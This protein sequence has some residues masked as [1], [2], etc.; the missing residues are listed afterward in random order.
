MGLPLDFLEEKKF[1]K[2]F[3]LILQAE[4][5]SKVCLKAACGGLM[6]VT[7]SWWSSLYVSLHTNVLGLFYKVYCCFLH[8]S[9]IEF[10]C[11]EGKCMQCICVVT[12][13][14]RLARDLVVIKS[15][16]K[17]ISDLHACASRCKHVTC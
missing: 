17:S 16:I 9:C 5:L 2:V 14:D 12:A 15:T 3:F 10:V 8:F 13:G 6:G 4:E 11:E 1:F 7:Q